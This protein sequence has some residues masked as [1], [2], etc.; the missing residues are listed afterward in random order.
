MKVVV[1]GGYIHGSTQFTVDIAALSSKEMNQGFLHKTSLMSQYRV[2][3][4]QTCMDES[5]P[6]H[7][8]SALCCQHQEMAP[9]SFCYVFRC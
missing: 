9:W 7:S 6:V 8:I 2:L 5:P 3:P 4:Q 1:V